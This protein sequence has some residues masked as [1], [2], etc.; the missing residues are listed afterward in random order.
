MEE[1]IANDDG[2]P[3]LLKRDYALPSLGGV[4]LTRKQKELQMKAGIASQ[5]DDSSFGDAYSKQISKLSKISKRSP[6]DLLSV[7]SAKK[8][9][10][11]TK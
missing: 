6:A 5:R 2:K 9:R 8:S 4:S 11:R 10:R 7:S 3:R 1:G